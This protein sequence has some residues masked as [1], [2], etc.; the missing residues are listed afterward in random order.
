MNNTITDVPGIRVGHA[1]HAKA[2]TGCTVVLCDRARGRG[3]VGGVD[4]RGGAPGTRETDLLRPRHL[5]KEVHAVLLAGGSAFGLA[6]AD[7]VVRYLE[8][9]RAGFNARVVRV[10]IVPAAILFDLDVGDPSVRPDAEMG[11]AACQAASNGPVAAGNVGAGTGATVGKILGMGHA[12]KGGLGTASVDLGGGLVVGALVAVNAFGDVIDPVNGRIVA[13]ARK[14]RGEGFADTLATMR[15]FVGKTILR[16]AA[17]A[18][19]TVIGVVATNARLTKDEANK[20]AQMAHDGLARAVRPAHTLYDGD[21]LFTLA[22]G[23]KQADVN[24]IGA[25]AAEVV[26][27]A[28]VRAARAAEGIPG[29]PAATDYKDK[30][31]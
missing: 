9:R 26:A 27:Q 28:I 10:P 4:Q 18:G 2:L 7:G 30:Q 15:G 31:A 6:A 22:M 19:N 5:V 24:L 13:G 1:T 23:A 16:F 17:S 12:M 11:Y 3:A 25:Y 8:E 14:V 20:V 29:F 21:T